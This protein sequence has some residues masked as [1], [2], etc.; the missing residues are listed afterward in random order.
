VKQLGIIIFSILFL[1][2]FSKSQQKKQYEVE[3][4]ILSRGNL[5]QNASKIFEINPRVLAVIIFTER[6][7]N[8]NWLDDELDFLLLQFGLNAS[9]GFCQIKFETADWIERQ[10]NWSKSNYYLSEKVHK[11]IKV[12]KD[13]GELAQKL[14]NDSVNILYAAVFLKMNIER[15][16]SEGSFG[17][18]GIDISENVGILGTLYSNGV[19]RSDANI[20]INKFGRKADEFYK[21]R[22]LLERFCN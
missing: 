8:H 16:K 6:Y 5:I 13:R 3:M 18:E 19:R 10:L 2:S 20:N 22:N 14:Q 1:I 7:L 9:V 12:S 17:K 11:V 4:S 15:W 21:S